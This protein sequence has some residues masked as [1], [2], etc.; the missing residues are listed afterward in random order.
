MVISCTGVLLYATFIMYYGYVIVVVYKHFDRSLHVESL[1][2]MC[3]HNVRPVP[4]TVFEIQGFKLKSENDDE[5]R[6]RMGEMDFLPY[7][8]CSL[9]NSHQILGSHIYRP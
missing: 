2:P 6:R 7:L 9:S 3:V 4:L 1:D 8:P 5:T